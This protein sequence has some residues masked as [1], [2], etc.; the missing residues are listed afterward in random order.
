M[1]IT[2]IAHS[3]RASIPGSAFTQ[4]FPSPIES[5]GAALAEQAHQCACELGLGYYPPLDFVRQQ[6]C[7][8]TYLLDAVDQVAEFALNHSKQEIYSLLQPVFSNVAIESLQL[9]CH[10]MPSV[11]PG[12]NH[13][14]TLLAAHY[15]PDVVKCELDVAMLQKHGPASAVE[16][17]D[18]VTASKKM[19]LRWLAESFADV[20][21]SSSRML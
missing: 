21:I 8:D 1:H 13:A 6:D 19:L 15:T 9:V 14:L 3:V 2:R 5:L 11:R 18:L 12:Q 20:N 17:L 7:V 10:T 4:F 16:R